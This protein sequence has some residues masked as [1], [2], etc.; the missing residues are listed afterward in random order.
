MLASGATILFA[1]LAITAFERAHHKGTLNSPTV[2][3]GSHF[4]ARAMR[5]LHLAGG[6]A[7]AA[8]IH[9]ERLESLRRLLPVDWP[10]IRAL[11]R[12]TLLTV[13]LLPAASLWH[14]VASGTARGVVVSISTDVF[15]SAAVLSL[16]SLLLARWRAR[17]LGT[18][19][20]LLSSGVATATVVIMLLFDG[21][22][23]I[24]GELGGFGQWIGQWSNMP[25]LPRSLAGAAFVGRSNAPL[26]APDAG[27]FIGVA[28]VFVTTVVMASRLAKR[29]IFETPILE[30]RPIAPLSAPFSADARAQVQITQFGFCMTFLLSTR[31]FGSFP[32]ASMCLALAVVLYVWGW[33]CRELRAKQVAASICLAGIATVVSLLMA[34][35]TGVPTARNSLLKLWNKPLDIGSDIWAAVVRTFTGEREV[36]LVMAF[37]ALLFVSALV[38]LRRP[39]SHLW[40]VIGHA[41]AWGWMLIGGLSAALVMPAAFA[42]GTVGALLMVLALS[43]AWLFVW[44]ERM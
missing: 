42:T 12:W 31:P 19:A 33:H 14:S 28:L 32:A 35:V 39:P 22:W 34:G 17:N 20:L 13:F 18:F 4:A 29:A 1:G 26:S 21:L 5:G 40:N 16:L 10:L 7:R 8:G 41:P 3:G 27:Y 15:C 2:H 37:I 11:V 44:L 24:R 36:S 6:W 30:V 23:R 9:A 38:L 25:W 43:T